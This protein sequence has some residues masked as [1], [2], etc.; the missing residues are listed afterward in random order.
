MAG[1]NNA[2]DGK[3][4]GGAPGAAGAAGAG[5]PKPGEQKPGE[6]G[7][8]AAK[9]GDG[10]PAGD[11]KPGDL[12][13]GEQK[14]GDK[15]A[16]APE[17]YADFKL[18]D[19]LTMDK[20]MVDKFT[21]LAKEMNLSQDAAQK[22]VDLQAEAVQAQS[23]AVVE[24]HNQTVATWKQDTIKALG[25]NHQ[26]ELADASKA[27]DKYGSPEL[28]QL[29]EDT[30]LGNHVEFAKFFAAVGKTLKEDSF[31]GGAGGSKAKKSDAEVFYGQSMG[32]KK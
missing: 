14:P 9:P 20:T 11:G 3:P 21:G 1:E 18:A 29:L 25:A 12:K 23:A 6:G 10:K 32:G 5:D 7:A 2:G 4:Q 27:L 24:A 17:K 28:K 13:P 26:A 16:G 15:P 8:P 30:G 19:G 31:P 22:L